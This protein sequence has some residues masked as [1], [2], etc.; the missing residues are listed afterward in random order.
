ML[1]I[2][3]YGL[4]NIIIQNGE[5]LKKELGFILGIIKTFMVYGIK[6][7]NYMP[8]QKLAPSTLSIPEAT[9]TVREKKG[10]KVFDCTKFGSV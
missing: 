5:Y 3:L 4:Q 9:N 1:Q 6:G 10:G 2:C 7:V 8:P